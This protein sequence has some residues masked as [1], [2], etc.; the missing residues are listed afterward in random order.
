MAIDTRTAARSETWAA[1]SALRSAIGA[2]L[3]LAG[4]VLL[5]TFRAIVIAF[6]G[7]GDDTGYP[8]PADIPQNEWWGISGA[9]IFAVIGIGILL[10]ATG[11][12]G[13][14]LT[15]TLG[16]IGG[17]GFLLCAGSVR[18]MWSF[19][20]ANLTETG[21]D[22]GAQTAAFWA[23]NIV[24]GG[25]LVAAGCTTAGWLLLLGLRGPR[26]R[27]VGRAAGVA[28]AIGAALIIVGELGPVI[29]AAQ[30][31]FVLIFAILTVSFWRR[32]RRMRQTS[33]DA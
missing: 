21:A 16:T 19:I 6:L 5:P 9:I 13:G 23:V 14:P 7:G 8:R 22:V 4:Y 29:L 18:G 30:F 11:V 17:A 12:P 20:S 32:A 24:G 3:A 15:R 26:E 27:T 25:L 1:A 33:A 2:T 31:V 28:L 10:V